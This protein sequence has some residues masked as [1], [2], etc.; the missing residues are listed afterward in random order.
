MPLAVPIEQFTIAR[1]EPRN[2]SVDSGVGIDRAFSWRSGSARRRICDSTR[3]LIRS[4]RHFVLPL[5]HYRIVDEI[6]QSIRLVLP[7][8]A[9][10]VAPRPVGLT[11]QLFPGAKGPDDSMVVAGWRS[12]FVCRLFTRWRSVPTAWMG[13]VLANGGTC[14]LCQVR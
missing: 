5:T 7:F 4:G 13:G 8:A 6:R 12:P 10:G 14:G 1:I 11:E 9:P 2:G 3:L